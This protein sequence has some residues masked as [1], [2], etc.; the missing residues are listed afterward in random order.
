MK[1]QG[2]DIIIQRDPLSYATGYTILQG[3]PHQTYDTQAM[4]YDPNRAY[5]PLVIMPWVNAQDTNPDSDYS[6]RCALHS[7]TAI[8]RHMVS[9]QW[10]DTPIDNTE[11]SKYYIS[12]GTTIQGVTAPV[13]AVV[14]F[15]NVP[16]TDVA[17]LVI[18]ANVVDQVD[19]LVKGFENIVEL[20]SKTATTVQYKLLASEDFPTSLDIWP[21]EYTKTNGHRL[22]TLSVQLYKENAVVADADCRYFWY[23]WDGTQYSPITND[24][25]CWLRTAFLDNTTFELP[26]TIQVDIDYFDRLRLMASASPIGETT[27]T[28]PDYL[29]GAQRVYFDYRR[30][31]RKDI[32]GFVFGE[33][34][35][36]IMGDDSLT[37]YLQL[38]GNDGD[39][40]AAQTDEMFR[41]DWYLK[42]GNSRTKYSRGQQV[43]GKAYTNFG[44]TSSNVTTLKPE[45]Y[46]LRAKKP[47]KVGTKY[48]ADSN[49][50]LVCG[51]DI[52]KV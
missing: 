35:I 27:P 1:I 42:N 21:L 31:C 9:N 37:R 25:Q 28:S 52:M 14:F 45:V 38:R 32:Q 5:V 3:S 2:S 33:K 18:T 20:T 23:L 19:G 36:K 29:H 6:G 17:S 50:R 22:L 4:E 34:G 16:P 11:T 48:L 44:A 7:V 12:D 30:M 51:Q 8:Y 13:G 41:V 46:F 47:V 24:N 39:L 40:T 10:V 15:L 26:G 49:G 43:E